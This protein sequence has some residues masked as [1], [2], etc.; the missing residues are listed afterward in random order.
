M[1][2]NWNRQRHIHTS[3]HTHQEEQAQCV[4]LPHSVDFLQ[5][6]QLCWPVVPQ[7]GLRFR[8]HHRD[9]SLQREEQV[10]WL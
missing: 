7:V 9:A 3:T 2:Q 10:Q 6:H 5:L 1:G 8:V 4:G